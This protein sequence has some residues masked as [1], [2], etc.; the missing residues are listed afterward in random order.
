MK[1]KQISVLI[2]GAKADWFCEK[3]GGRKMTNAE[4]IETLRANYPDACFEQ[5]R[6]AVDVAI[7]ALKAQDIAGDTISRQW[8]LDCINDGWIKFD[9]DKDTNRFIHLVRDIAPP[10]Q[11]EPKRRN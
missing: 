8:L 11:P 10:A 3:D 4:A 7:K 9:T 1:K 2:V 6:E 5:L